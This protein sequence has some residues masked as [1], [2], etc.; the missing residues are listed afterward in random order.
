MR[1]GSCLLSLAL[2]AGLAVLAGC[3]DQHIGRMCFIQ[4]DLGTKS[5]SVVVNPQALECPSRLCLHHPREGGAADTSDSLDGDSLD[6][7][8][9]ECESN[10]DCEG[11]T[12]STAG[13]CKHGFVC[14][15]PVQV[16]G[17][18]CCKRLC[19]CKDLIQLPEG[20]S[21]IT[22]PKVCEPANRQQICQQP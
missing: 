16:P 10:D 20:S 3:E 8:T 1:I 17:P 11:Q 21:S 4:R 22:M 15:W 2:V 6:L 7:C 19:V 9:A 12:G 5:P 13:E 18:L 14:D